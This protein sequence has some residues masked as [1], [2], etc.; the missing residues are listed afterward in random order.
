[1]KLARYRTKKFMVIGGNQMVTGE[2]AVACQ[3][4]LSF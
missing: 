4:L 3:G 1:M 2:A